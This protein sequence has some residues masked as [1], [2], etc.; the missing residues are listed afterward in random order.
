MRW[1][2]V[3][4]VANESGCRAVI[5]GNGHTLTRL[6]RGE[7]VANGATIVDDGFRNAAHAA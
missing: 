7:A 4:A 2:L 1:D 5:L 6:W 3:T